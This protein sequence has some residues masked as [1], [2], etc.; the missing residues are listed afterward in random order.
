MQLIGQRAGPFLARF[1]GK[2]SIVPARFVRKVG[3]NLLEPRWLQEQQRLREVDAMIQQRLDRA[4]TESPAA[5]TDRAHDA[6]ELR[7][8][9]RGV[10]LGRS[11]AKAS[12]GFSAPR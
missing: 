7:R 4:I 12:H 2:A 9:N 1:V 5:K 10:L 3:G 11:H 8:G 6:G